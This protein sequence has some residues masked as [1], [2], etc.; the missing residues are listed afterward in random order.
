MEHAHFAKQNHGYA[1]TLAL[2]N[3]CAQF[4][5]HG[6]DVVPLHVGAGRM[7]KQQLERALVLPLHGRRWYQKSVPYATTSEVEG[8]DG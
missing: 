2:R 5:E 4:A 1:A 7:G 3:F 8:S 6:F